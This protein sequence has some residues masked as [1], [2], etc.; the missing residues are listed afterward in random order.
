MIILNLHYHRSVTIASRIAWKIPDQMKRSIPTWTWNHLIATITL[1]TPFRPNLPQNRTRL[2][3]II[4]SIYYLA[5]TNPRSA[6]DIPG[7]G[8]TDENASREARKITV[9]EGSRKERT[10]ERDK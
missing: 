6:V 5:Y 2:S 7:R 3:L 9:A 1:F 8:S 10:P 4:N